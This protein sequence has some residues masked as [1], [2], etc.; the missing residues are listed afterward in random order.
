M[1]AGMKSFFSGG[2][3]KK[4]TKELKITKQKTSSSKP[5]KET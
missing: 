5:K 1:L 2:A 3:K 4:D